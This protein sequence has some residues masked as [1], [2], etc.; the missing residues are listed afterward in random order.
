MKKV[1][2]LSCKDCWWFHK[3]LKEESKGQCFKYGFTVEEKEPV[4][5]DYDR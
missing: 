1:A 4:C 3:Y 2:A 5:C